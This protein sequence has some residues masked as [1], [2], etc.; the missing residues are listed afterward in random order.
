MVEP[1]PNEIYTSP[2]LTITAF[3]H[4]ALQPW[5]FCARGNGGSAV[6]VLRPTCRMS[7]AE[8]VWF[9][10]QV[11]SQ[12]WRFH[13]GRMATKGRLEKL[14]V[15]HP[16]LD[17][18]MIGDVAARVK[19][20]RDDVARLSGDD[21]TAVEFANLA[22]H[23]R[24]ERGVSSSA[25][26]L[27]AHSAYLRIIGMGE[28]AVPLILRELST[29]P[30]HWFVALHSITGANPVSEHARGRLNKMAEAWITWGKEQGFV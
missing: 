10:G 15:L 8:M 28:R 26:Q 4:A 17:L 14:Q 22:D 1:P 19:R 29:T 30:D 25:A 21:A 16:P 2:H 23:W 6:R 18:D 9:I 24:M 13:Y 27:A 5:D 12:R 7:V 3:G 11:N 20:F